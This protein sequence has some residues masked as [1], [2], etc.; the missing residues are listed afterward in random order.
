MDGKGPFSS[1]VMAVVVV[2]D[3]VVI[4][5]YAINVELIRVV[6]AQVTSNPEV[7]VLTCCAVWRVPHG[8]GRGGLRDAVGGVRNALTPRGQ[9]G[10]ARRRTSR[11]RPRRALGIWTAWD[12]P[13]HCVV[14]WQ[15]GGSLV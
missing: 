8:P 4:I 1:L 5:A 9:G 10:P 6:S 12:L 3:V 7:D 11:Q 13:L 15:P 14:R 2:K